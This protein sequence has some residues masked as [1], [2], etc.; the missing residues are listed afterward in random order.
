MLTDLLDNQ[1]P[2]PL[3]KPVFELTLSS[4]GSSG[5]LGGLSDAVSSML[6][7]SNDPWLTHTV[8]IQVDCGLAPMVDQAEIIVGPGSE[9]PAAEIDDDATISLGYSDDETLPVFSGTVTQVIELVDGS[10]RIRLG[11]A[12]ELLAKKR[13]NLS[14]QQQSAAD[15]TQQLL[16][17]ADIDSGTIDDSGLSLPFYAVDDRRSF[18]QHVA[19]LAELSGG[20]VMMTPDNTVQVIALASGDVV[21]TFHYGDTLLQVQWS[22]VQASAAKRWLGEGAAGSNGTEAWSWLLK[23][24]DNMASGEEGA[25]IRYEPT[26]RAKE[27]VDSA[28]EGHVVRNGRRA[29]LFTAGAPAVVTGSTVE[30]A[31]SP[32][33]RL[34]GS[35]VVTRV[36]HHLSRHKGFF[37]T[38]DILEPAEGGSAGLGALL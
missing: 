16:S 22:T 4:G 35:G 33:G 24:S 1:A 25:A 29:R 11:N 30:V 15:I 34:D 17:E 27:A 18:Y 36:R 37:S 2:A 12:S 32:E 8:A 19:Q 26:L 28:A 9:S 13:T 7:G 31:G 5:G 10:R 6:A 23:S 3:R 38:I 20:I 21:Q 14:F